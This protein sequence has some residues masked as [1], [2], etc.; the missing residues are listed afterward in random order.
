MGI[1]NL[2]HIYTLG[3]DSSK[4]DALETKVNNLSQISAKTNVAQTFQGLQTFNNGAASNILPTANTHL[5][6]KSY[7][8]TRTAGFSLLQEW[9]GNFKTTNLTWTKTLNTGIYEFFVM[10]INGGWKSTGSFTMEV[11]T[12]NNKTITPVF[13]FNLANENSQSIQN[14]P[15]SGWYFVWNGTQVKIVKVGQTQPEANTSVYIYHRKLP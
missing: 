6:N 1:T 5:A 15:N 12:N 8:D 3:G 4:I 14:L 9:S 13:L 10:V 7:V 2:D 11:S